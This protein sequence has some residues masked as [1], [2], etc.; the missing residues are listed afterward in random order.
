M[1]LEALEG[2][3]DGELLV[4]ADSGCTMSAD[5]SLSFDLES[6]SCGTQPVNSSTDG[7]DASRRQMCRVDV[8][9]ALLPE[10]ILQVR[11]PNMDAPGAAA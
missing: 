7:N 9:R 11:L 8:A 3:Q 2:V 5:S 4:Y 1:I 10:P 6:G